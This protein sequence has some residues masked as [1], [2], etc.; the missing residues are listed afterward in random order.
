MLELAPLWDEKNP[1]YIRDFAAQSFAF[2]ARKVKD[3]K[4]FIMLVLHT[5]QSYP[6]V[7]ILFKHFHIF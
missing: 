1:E 7:T 5:A 4:K 2:V 3:K 6:E